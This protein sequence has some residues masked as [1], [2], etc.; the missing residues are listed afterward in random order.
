MRQILAQCFTNVSV[1]LFMILGRGKEQESRSPVMIG[2]LDVVIAQHFGSPPQ[3]A[4][5]IRHL[6]KNASRIGFAASEIKELA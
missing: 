4:G 5:G 6:R 2:R 3:Q 1:V